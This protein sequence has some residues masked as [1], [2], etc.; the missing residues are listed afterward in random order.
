MHPQFNSGTLDYDLAVLTFADP[1]TAAE[2]RAA[3]V[4]RVVYN[5]QGSQ[6]TLTSDLKIA[7]WGNISGLRQSISNSLRLASVK[8]NTWQ[9]CSDYYNAKFGFRLSTASAK[10]QICAS[11]QDKTATC[12]GDSGGPLF[13]RLTTSTGATYYKVYGV[14]SYGYPSG[15]NACPVD[16]SDFFARTNAGTTF[17]KS[18]M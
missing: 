15:S 3:G 5:A 12:N 6:P 16:N 9:S 7:G 8:M 1:P 13:Q 11:T 18:E 14:V 17:I 4:K 2:Y 10:L